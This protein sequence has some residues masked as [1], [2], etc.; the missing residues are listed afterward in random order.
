MKTVY[1]VRH[2]E[3]E[4]NVGLYYQGETNSPLTQHGEEQARLVAQ[5]CARLPIDVL[6]SSTALR[7][8]QT[9]E[10]ISAQTGL[11]ADYTDLF[12]ERRR[13]SEVIGK[14][15]DDPEASRIEE[16]WDRSLYDENT[17][18]FDG[19]HFGLLKSRAE[20][21]LQYLKE[22]QENELLVVTHGFFLRAL[23]AYIVFGERL[24]GSELRKFIHAMRTTNTGISM[25]T[26]DRNGSPGWHIR[27]YNDAS[28]LA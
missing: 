4:G 26:D 21:A 12:V 3:S 24:T 5:R 15:Y 20:A 17:P 8:K 14:R 6:I 2:G 28:H 7:A 22:R 11:R 13:P 18:V 10:I 16:E 23:F 9:A 25:I 27:L 1:F 19:E